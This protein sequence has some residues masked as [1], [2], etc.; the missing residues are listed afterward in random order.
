MIFISWAN[1][2]KVM[3]ETFLTSLFYD[4]LFATILY[5][6]IDIYG[7]VCFLYMVY[8]MVYT[9]ATNFKVKGLVTE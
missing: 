1:I 6:Y 7:S 2:E 5:N 8:T 9:E 4:F 3:I